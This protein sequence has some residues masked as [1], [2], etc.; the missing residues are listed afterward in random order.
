MWSAAHRSSSPVPEL[1][2]HAVFFRRLP[3]AATA[4]ATATASAKLLDLG[5]HC[6]LRASPRLP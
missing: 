3:A 1:I 6:L 4:T 5:A 2:F